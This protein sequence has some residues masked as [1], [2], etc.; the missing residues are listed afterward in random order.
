[1][2]YIAV[3]SLAVKSICSTILFFIQ[4]IIA[5]AQQQPILVNVDSGWAKNSVNVTVFRKN[6]LVTYKDT[7]FVAYY[8]AEQNVVLGKRKLGTDIW[9]IQTTNY[10]GNAADAHNVISIMVD[11]EG[12]LHIAWDHHNNALNYCKS[13]EPGSL[14]LSGKM[15]MTGSFEQSITYP[16]FYTMPDGNLLFFYRNGAS[17]KGNL[18]INKY[19]TKTKQWNQ[20]QQN[21]IDG[22]SLRNAYWQACVDAAGTIHISW[23]WRETADVGSNHDICYAKSADGG[24]TWVT[25]T[26]KQYQLPVTAATAEYICHIPQNSELI[27]QTSM[28]ADEEG[29][30]FI[31]T[32]YR[33]TNDAV[34]QYHVLY[35][36]NNKWEIQNLG[37]RKMPF[38]LSGMG[39][40]RIPIARPQI[41]IWKEGLHNCAAVIFRDAERGNKISAAINYDLLKN[42]WTIKDLTK[43]SVGSWEP[44]YD[45]E[46]WKTKKLLHLFVQYADQQDA[47][48]KAE[49]APQVVQVLE[50][51]PLV[52]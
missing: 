10:K 12:Y 50:W 13:V 33:D 1:L 8:N 34:P 37:F 17:G 11:G 39:T 6:S 4:F 43:F 47:E 44:S 29:H 40:K 51:N 38:S 32:Y 18:V 21:L 27:N 16:E 48:G 23:V 14:Q 35:N 45:T 24:N 52:K 36:A 28:F 49:I 25:S 41:V 19:N 9:Q 31:A 7:Q 22:E 26:G 2:Q 3:N 42:N 15:S 20:L 5:H 46:F 30:P